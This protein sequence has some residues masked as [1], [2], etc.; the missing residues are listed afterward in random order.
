MKTWPFVLIAGLLGVGLL[1]GSK[2]LPADTV[3]EFHGKVTEAGT[4]KPM[5]DTFVL[6]N[7][8]GYREEPI[9]GH[10]NS[11]CIPASAAVRTDAQGNY[12]YRYDWSKDGD[13]GIPNGGVRMQ[14]Y[15][16]GYERDV[17]VPTLGE[18][19]IPGENVDFVLRKAGTDLDSRLNYLFHAVSESCARN[20]THD[21]GWYEVFLAAQQE[22]WTNY[23]TNDG[24]WR[25]LRNPKDFADIAHWFKQPLIIRLYL[26]GSKGNEPEF[27]KA[28]DLY[29]KKIQNQVPTYSPGDVSDELDALNKYAHLRWQGKPE[30][31][32]S[33]LLK[34]CNLFSSKN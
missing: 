16:A 32:D 15:K 27:Y 9:T 3:L 17:A 30:I 18:W 23:C 33:Q 11:G 21:R 20:S 13:K 7:V 19:L 2:F 22:V 12:H 14:V 34:V 26:D 8:M 31:T 28:I 4:G 24:A 10:G 5:P 6:I 29:T 25:A 1:V